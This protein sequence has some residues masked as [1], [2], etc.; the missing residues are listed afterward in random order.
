MST[1]STSP[2]APETVEVDASEAIDI[3]QEQGP[4]QGVAEKRPLTTAD[5]CDAC[6]ARAYVRVVLPIGELMFCGHHGRMHTPV[7]EAQALFIQDETGRL[8][9]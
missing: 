7:L 9:A 4:S 3:G 8:S 6:G 1:T 5:R 2:A